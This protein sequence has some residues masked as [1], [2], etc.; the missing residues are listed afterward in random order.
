MNE[1]EPFAQTWPGIILQI[2]MVVIMGYV[3]VVLWTR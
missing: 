3:T 2:I 1:H